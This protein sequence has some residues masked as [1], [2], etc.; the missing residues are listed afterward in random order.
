MG[1][2]RMLMKEMGEG[3][4]WA[5]KSDL[6]RILI[7]GAFGRPELRAEERKH[8]L[9]EL[10]ERVLVHL[11]RREIEGYDVDAKVAKAIADPRAKGMVIH[12][13]VPILASSK[14]RK[15]AEAHGLTITMREDPSYEG[16]VGLVVVSDAAV[17]GG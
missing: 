6:E 13:D 1:F 17:T 2:E 16:D 8:F 14:Y 9:G 7:E 4:G 12:A 10:E 3:H 15:L 5:D 11:T